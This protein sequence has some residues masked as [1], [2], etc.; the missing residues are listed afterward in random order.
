MRGGVGEARWKSEGGNSECSS[1]LLP[2]Y[3]LRES[4]LLK[5]RLHPC[6]PISI[7]TPR[8]LFS[9][10]FKIPCNRFSHGDGHSAWGGV[11]VVGVLSGSLG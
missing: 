11:A 5:A 7:G 6:D 2:S 1:L 3:T 4:A 8:K 9:A 10:I